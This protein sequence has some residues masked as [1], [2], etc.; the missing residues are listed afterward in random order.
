MIIGNRSNFAVEFELDKEYNGVWLFGKFRYWIKGRRI[1]DYEMGASLRDVLFSLDT[2]LYDIGNRT[3]VKLFSLEGKELFAML[4]NT[5]Y[6]ESQYVEVANEE[7]WARFNINLPVDI[8]DDYR[9]YIVE[10]FE[11]ARILIKHTSDI[12]FQEVKLPK[13]MFD[14]VI[15][16]AHQELDSLYNNEVEKDSYRNF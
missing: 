7:N 3:H 11:T 14:E 6:E 5:F 1:G 13:G 9:M 12:E 8:F 16:K 4:D 10:N 15:L 2:I